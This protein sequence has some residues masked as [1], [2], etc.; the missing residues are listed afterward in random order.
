MSELDPIIRLRCDFMRDSV[1]VVMA[2]TPEEREL[3]LMCC[4]SILDAYI[5]FRLEN[6]VEVNAGDNA[7]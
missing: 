2:G 5:Q 3:A 4:N 6:A 7:D 1:D